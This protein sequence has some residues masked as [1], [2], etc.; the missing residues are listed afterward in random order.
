MVGILDEMREYSYS[1]NVKLLGVSQ[2]GADEN[3]VQTSN[4]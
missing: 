3:A 1:F 4:L 2:L